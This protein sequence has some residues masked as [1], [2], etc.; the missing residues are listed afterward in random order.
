MERGRL[1]ERDAELAVLDEQLDAAAAG[2]GS[3]VVVEGPAGIG[4][5]RLLAAA[6]ER[7]RARGFE[8]LQG[9]GSPLERDVQ[10]GLVR[11]LIERPIALAS[12]A[13]RD[14][15]L[16]GPAAPAAAVLGLAAPPAG[17]ALDDPAP[18]ILQALHWVLLHLASRA[19]LLVSVDDGHWGD[20]SSLRVGNYVSRR[21]EG[22]PVAIVLGTR[23]DEPSPELSLL[24]DLVASAEPWRH[25]RPAPLSE[26][27]AAEIVAA[28]FG[29]RPAPE[30]LVRACH[31]ATL[32]NP[33]LLGELAKDLAATHDA[34]GDV[35]PASVEEAGPVAV[36]RST[37]LRLGRLPQ[38]AQALARAVAVLGGDADPRV[39]A[40]MAELDEDEARAAADVLVAAGILDVRRTLRFVHPLVRAAIGDDLP[41]GARAAE[42]RRALE[43]LR[44]A[45]AAEDALL[46]HALACA[47]AGD[48]FVVG[49]LREAAARA[50]A[51]GA[52]DAAA[53]YLA[54]AL[55]EPPDEREVP[56]VLA[57]LGV[58]R[59]RAGDFAGGRA[60]LERAATRAPGATARA[61]LALDRAYGALVTDGLGAAARVVEEAVGALDGAEPD[62]A[63]GLEAELALLTWMTGAP[64]P[65]L[66]RLER[67]RDVA[68][69]TAAERT[70]LALLSQR[71]TQRGEDPGAAVALALRALGGGR[72]LR[73]DTG[74]A[75]SWFLAVYTLLSCE[76]L[77]EAA[78][79]IEAAVADARR[80]GAAF[81]FAGA[82]GTRAVLELARGRLREAEA[83][84]RAA[85]GETCPDAMR[86]V[87]HAYTVLALLA[88]GE[89]DAAGEVLRAAGLE[90]A[91]AGPSVLRWLAWARA[92]LRLAQ[93]RPEEALADLDVLREDEEA[94][95]AWRALPW[96]IGAAEAWRA[97]GDEERAAALAA[98]QLAWA[99]AWGRPAALGLALAAAAPAGDA[100][101]RAAA[102]HEA[103]SVL[104]G[105]AA[106]HEEAAVRTDLGIALLRAGRRSDGRAELER[107][108]ELARAAGARAT[109]RRAEEELEVAGARPRRLMFDELTASER[110]VAEMAAR[111]M[112]NREIAEALFVTPK[113][114]ENQLGR[115]YAK[116]GISSRRDLPAALASAA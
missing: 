94:G 59:L 16:S 10:F 91:P 80:R 69:E 106:R 29:G 19:P 28:A 56:D 75:R 107:G 11:Q 42:H 32:G 62:L 1:L 22:L 71:E 103:A 13:E 47:P 36:R 23:D 89:V 45:G 54:R 5:T 100:G 21:L 81:A 79:A 15:L 50:Q 57:A 96:R 74:E 20:A 6:R 35:A 116:L 55:D 92:R 38:P 24:V 87:G 102:L 44:A 66:D 88:Q 25:L 113:T 97:L 98:E 86:P 67:R 82:M 108:L 101:A 4:K 105:S 53:R 114:V 43:V 58:A 26:G 46:P 8:V 70:L 14:R 68:G 111:G 41:P 104:A 7:A 31:A 90:T 77:E 48:P 99:R 37:L 12:P 60:D 65:V 63:L 64:H 17:A 115:A 73:E 34:P 52:P 112:T 33:F 2:H 61:R 93:G 95:Q 109:A 83:D 110:R 85:A 51:G 49:L 40:R 84:A 78:E 18:Q 30:P 76:A 27:A 3:L 72:L 9:R 39:A